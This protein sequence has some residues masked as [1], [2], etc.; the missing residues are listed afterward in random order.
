MRLQHHHIYYIWTP[1]SRSNLSTHAVITQYYTNVRAICSGSTRHPSHTFNQR[2]STQSRHRHCSVFWQHK[3]MRI[4][5]LLRHHTEMT[6]V[7]LKQYKR[8][9]CS[10]RA[11]TKPVTWYIQGSKINTEPSSP[12][13]IVAYFD[14]IW[15]RHCD[16]ILHQLKTSS[17]V[18]PKHTRSN[19]NV[20][21]VRPRWNP[22]REYIQPTKMYK[23]RAVIV[24]VMRLNSTWWG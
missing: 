11:D 13:L 20:R 7:K 10:S 16:F 2:R 8:T 12:L 5:R 21:A 19:I 6:R 17:S 1:I 15:G 22:F 23:S 4:I 24:I 3:M 9:H 14:S 18:K